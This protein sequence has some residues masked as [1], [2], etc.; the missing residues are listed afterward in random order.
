MFS[1]FSANFSNTF[2]LENLEVQKSLSFINFSRKSL[3]QKKNYNLYS[4]YFK[5]VNNF[6]FFLSESF[7]RI[8]S[9]YFFTFLAPLSFL[10]LFPAKHFFFFQRRQSSF[11]TFS[12]FSYLSL[13][14]RISLNNIFLTL[15]NNF[16]NVLCSI[17]GGKVGLK[18][19]K[20]K[21]LTALKLMLFR[22]V[23]F[24]KKKRLENKL[25]FLIVKTNWYHFKRVVLRDLF[26][27]GIE[28][29]FIIFDFKRCHNGLRKRKVRNR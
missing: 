15:V 5:V 23:S 14:L 25:L 8:C 12:K 26:S 6:G 2:V 19:F 1:Y 10:L 16:G 13:V 18:G 20:R 27:R 3:L 22:I 29:N 24:L 28:I 11:F 17:S 9:L 4:V 7:F 21:T